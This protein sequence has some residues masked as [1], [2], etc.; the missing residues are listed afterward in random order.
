VCETLS[1]ARRA[2]SVK[3]SLSVVGVLGF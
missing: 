1:F 3:Q 2:N